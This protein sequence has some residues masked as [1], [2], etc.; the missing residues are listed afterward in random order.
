MV[1]GLLLSAH[2][3]FKY[4]KHTHKLLIWI[5]IFYVSK[6]FEKYSASEYEFKNVYSYKKN[7]KKTQKL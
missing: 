3:N 6:Y 4:L 1:N 2:Q 5:E 7:L